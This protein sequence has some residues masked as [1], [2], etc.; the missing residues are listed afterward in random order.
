MII[1]MGNPIQTL[2]I[3]AASL[4]EVD[5]IGVFRYAHTYPEVIELLASNNPA[6]P[7]VQALITQRFQGLDSIPQAFEMAAKTRDD[8]GNLVLKV[9]VDM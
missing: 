4:R 6:L 7:N 5:L 8:K 9:M 1:G 2:P 3:S